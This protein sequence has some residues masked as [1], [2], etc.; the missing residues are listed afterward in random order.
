MPKLSP[1]AEEIKVKSLDENEDEKI[2]SVPASKK[3]IKRKKA[4]KDEAEVD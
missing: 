1:P 4:K 3:V 2:N